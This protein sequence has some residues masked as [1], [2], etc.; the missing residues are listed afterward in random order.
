MDYNPDKETNQ[1]IANYWATFCQANHL[2]LNTIHVADQFGH[3]GIADELAQLVLDGK[4]TATCSA[5]KL[6]EVEGDNLPEPGLY[7]IV[8]NSQDHPLCIIKTTEV[9]LVPMN[10]VPEAL[11]L[12]E[13][14]G[15][16]QAW[17]DG[18]FHYF[19]EEFKLYGRKFHDD[20]LL[21]FERFELVDTKSIA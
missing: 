5:H 9:H 18:H 4:K 1:I 14:E 2:P 12:A 20:E 19:T 8:L 11:A 21:V 7:T 13:G 15:S 16:H 3:Q 10:A 17:Y 6:Y